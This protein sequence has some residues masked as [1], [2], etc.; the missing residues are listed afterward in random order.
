MTL[1]LFPE[2]DAAQREQRLRAIFRAW[3]E[4]RAGSTSRRRTERP[5]REESAK[6]FQ[7]MWHAFAAYCAPRG[8]DLADIDEDDLQTFLVVRGSGA[9]R[10]PARHNTKGDELSAR[11]AWRMLWLIDQVTRFDAGV[12]GV[13]PN[14]A[15][16]QLLH[17]PAYRYANAAQ[18]DPLPEFYTEAQA[19]RLIAYL[20]QLAH[21]EVA[22]QPLPWKAL[23]DC[24]ALALMLGGGLTPGDVRALTLDA[25]AVDGGRKQ[26][27]PWKL[28]LPG[29][30]NAPARE[31]PIAPWA[32]RQLAFWLQVRA[33]QGI[34]GDYVF[35]ATGAGTPWSHTGCY[36]ACKAALDAAGM[37]DDAGGMFKLRHT[38]AL[39][40]LAKGR[41]ESEVARWLGLLDVNGMERY[42]RV[43]LRHVS[44][45]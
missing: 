35:P 41:T 8:L 14:F 22:A 25:V 4:H 7:D 15:A 12:A 10:Q 42:R 29:N 44:V 43:L 3:L 19:K 17:R 6:V 30:G 38:F 23:R 33:E 26:G 1:S 34:P 27:V 20:T 5:L 28:S 13:A 45:V 9:Q 18:H 37:G 40:Q 24:T 31:T 21:S 32:G 36:K 2:A 11:Y 16:N 39:R